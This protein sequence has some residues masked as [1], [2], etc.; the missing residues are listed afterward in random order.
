MLTTL[1]VCDLCGSTEDKKT[2]TDEPRSKDEL[3][4]GWISVY[5]VDSLG[6]KDVCA[7]CTQLIV[8]EYRN[9][10]DRLRDLK[11]SKSK[12]LN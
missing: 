1:F 3:P 9:A 12:K 7:Y 4:E 10:Q 11:S 2:P 5:P 8:D 6:S